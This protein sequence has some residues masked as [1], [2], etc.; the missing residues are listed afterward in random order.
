MSKE[1]IC[2]ASLVVER[3]NSSIAAIAF[4]TYRGIKRENMRDMTV[5]KTPS[6]RWYLYLKK[7]L[8]TCL[9]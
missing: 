6:I 4:L 1:V 5:I 8:R 7:Y 9:R 3:A 2:E